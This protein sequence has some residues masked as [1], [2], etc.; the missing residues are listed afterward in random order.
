M[1]ELKPCPFCGA[2]VE[3]QTIGPEPENRLFDAAYWVQCSC[4]DK[5]PCDTAEEAAETWNTRPIEDALRQ[6]HEE[7]AQ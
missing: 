2:A 1:H 4:L 5:L 7:N 6:Q 3:M